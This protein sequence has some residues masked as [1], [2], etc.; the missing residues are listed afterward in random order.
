MDVADVRIIPFPG[1]PLE[2]ETTNAQRTFFSAPERGFLI[3]PENFLLEPV[4]Q[5]AVDETMPEGALP[6]TFFGPSGCGKTHLLQGIEDSWRKTNLS[7]AK[8]KRAFYLKAVDFARQFAAAIEARTVDDFRRRYREATLLLIDDLAAIEEKP[9]VQEEL[10]FTMDVL[11][12]AGRTIVFGDSRF[13]GEGGRYSE[14]LTTRLLGGTTIPVSLPGMA[15]RLRFLRELSLAFRTVLPPMALEFAAKELP[16]PLPALYGLFAQMFFEAKVNGTKIDT[17]FV[18]KYLAN[19]IIADRPTVA[20]IAKKT[21]KHFSLKLADLRGRS[22][23]KTVAKARAVAV[24]LVRE[25]TGLN[26]KEIGQYFDGR[27]HTTIQH[28]A[29]SIEAALS[30]DR[31]LRDAVL[32]LR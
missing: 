22:R 29:E 15:V 11:L 26:L 14:R 10:L 30:T 18:K 21:A 9:L 31:L 4:V 19:R 2:F 25:R 5:W 17:A 20:E 7:D 1:K 13:P 16:L 8:K 24:Y 12:A 28:L 3:G 6:L 32:R 27:D 23:S